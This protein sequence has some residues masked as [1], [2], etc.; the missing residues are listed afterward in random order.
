[1][2]PGYRKSQGLPYSGADADVVEAPAGSVV[3]F[4]ARTWHRAGVN[5]T[6]EKRGAIVQSVI[7]AFL[8]PFADTSASYKALLASDVYA[9]LSPRVRSELERPLV[10]RIEGLAG[11]SAITTDSGLADHLHGSSPTS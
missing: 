5:R 9:E 2:V 6:S 7:P 8:M 4:Y 11:T 10:H 1:M 3:L